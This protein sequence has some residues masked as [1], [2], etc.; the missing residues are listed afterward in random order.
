[1]SKKTFLRGAAILGIAGLLVQVMGAFF[2]I[3][4]GNI[5]GD[6]GM[7]YYQ[8]AYPIYV[9]LLVF[10]TNGAPAAISKMTSE[11]IAQGKHSEAHRVFKLSFILMF[12]IGIIAFAIFFF[13][14]EIIVNLLKNPGAYYAMIAI[15]P[16]LLFVPIMAVYRGYFQGMQEMEPTAISQLVEQ[17]IRVIV[18]LGLAIF[19]LPRGLELAASGATFGTSIGPIAGVIMLIILYYRKRTKL[20]KEIEEDP[21][22]EKEKAGKILGTLAAIAIPITIGVSI[23]PIM[24]IVDVIIVMRRL[25]DVGFSLQSANALYGQLTGMAGPVINIPM[26]LALSIALSMV[27]AI[28]AANSVKD[29]E[30]LNM[31]IK[32]GLRTAMMI[33]VPC[34][35]GLMTLAEPIMLLLYPLQAES[36]SSAAS[37]LFILSIGILFLTVGQTMAGILQGLGKPYTAVIAL[38]VGVVVKA[39]ATYILAGIPSLNIQGAAW[40]STL[41]YL[42]IGLVN[43]IA[44]K[45]LTGIKFD[46]R[47]AVVKPL[48]SGITMSIFVVA[49]FYIVRPAVGGSLATIIAIAIG[50]AAY[51]ITLLKTK[52]ITAGEIRLLPKGEKLERLLNKLRL[53]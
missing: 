3:P 52:A 17:A 12:I 4:L 21:H 1:M 20:I 2:R 8:T 25:Q 51:G 5:I 19:L 9:F 46:Y 39:I 34:A 45:N 26:A 35:F 28:A 41:G 27:P 13:G 18:G 50:A 33:G 53:I 40:G 36:A 16:A 49:A 6:E 31:N 7:G 32:L 15:A 44:V 48:I 30:F 43:F 22:Q 37:S 11:R 47:L 29:T 24:N 10:S 42:V 38:A 23:L 14:A